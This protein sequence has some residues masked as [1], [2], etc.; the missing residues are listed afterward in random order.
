MRQ[1]AY[2]H[3]E[4]L[5]RM[6]SR[7]GA[8]PVILT[9]AVAMGIAA[10]L[11]LGSPARF[12]GVGW[13]VA[14]HWLPRPVWAFLFLMIAVAIVAACGVGREPLMWALRLSAVPWAF[15][16]ASFA[17][18]AFTRPDVSGSGA[19]SYGYI[20]AAYLVTAERFTP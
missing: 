4:V 5:A 6:D 2:P 3:P 20:A 16:A 11:G 1:I 9:V 14:F 18:A 13:S 15:Y 12:G 8:L 10:V 19:I 7:V 17:V